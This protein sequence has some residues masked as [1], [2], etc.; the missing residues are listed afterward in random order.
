MNNDYLISLGIGRNQKKILKLICGIGY[1]NII[2]I[3]NKSFSIGSQFCKKIFKG[4]IYNFN[5]IKKIIPKIKKISTDFKVIFRSS[6]PSI[7]SLYILEKHSNFIRVEKDLAYS[8]YSKSYFSNLLK[9]KKLPFIKVILKEKFN[10]KNLQ[11]EMWVM[12]P[13][14]PIIGKKNVYLIN[15]KNFK[16]KDF[17]LCKKESH[18]N[19]VLFSEFT[20]GK[21]VTIFFLKS[22]KF[23]FKKISIIN[24]WV[25]LK[26][27]KFYGVGISNP[28]ISL[29]KKTQNEII[30]LSKKIIG[31]FINF[32]GI[33]S[34]SFRVN[35]SKK[36][37]LPYEINIGLSGDGFAD[38]IYPNSVKG[39]SLYKLEIDTLLNHKIQKFNFHNKTFCGL[40]FG[41]MIFN[42]N[43]FLNKIKNL[44][45]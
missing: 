25:A 42:K 14:A 24:E 6:G 22:H 19:K 11:N 16:K 26:N 32:K 30:K 13:D 17:N 36:Y 18:N 35:I 45:I 37:I 10:S 31:N 29:P 28:P 41:K 7:I 43:T 9:K 5:F 21:D 23:K 27:N 39:P 33:A 8:I 3:D 1:K 34:I 15:K 20:D 40:Y 2:G 4:S 44:K 38:K 12:K